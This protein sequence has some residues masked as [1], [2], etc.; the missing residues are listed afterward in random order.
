MDA[1]TARDRAAELVAPVIDPATYRAWLFLLASFPLGVVSFVWIV[2]TLTVGVATSF[3]L[4]GIPVVAVSVLGARVLGSMARPLARWGLGAQIPEPPPVPP[5][6]GLF[7]WLRS[8]LTDAA[9]WR[10]ML[11]LFLLFP[12]G[13]AGG[14]LATVLAATAVLTPVLLIGPWIIK[15]VS[16][17]IRWL[18]ERLLAPVT[19]SERARRLQASRQQV[20]DTAA[21]DLRRIE[22]DLH[23]GAQARL[24]ALAMDLGMAREKLATGGDPD[25]VETLV[26][27]AHDEVKAAL[28]E[29]REL[30]RGIHPAVLTDLG[31]DA[32]L[33]SVAARCI[34][35]VELTVSVP[36]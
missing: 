35:P 2:T 13:L 21:D 10:T 33:S 34:V 1:V 17:P 27:T 30:A 12:I 32:A 22:R 5:E 19:L 18:A 8:V 6:P 14:V 25:Q 28:I 15:A 16:A 31:L 26:A 9:G 3:T 7:G 4:V 36:T 24:V 20:V 23:D 29:L 11:Y